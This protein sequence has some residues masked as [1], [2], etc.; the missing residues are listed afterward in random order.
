MIIN[1]LRTTTIL[2]INNIYKKVFLKVGKSGGKSVLLD[3]L[4]RYDKIT[5]TI[6]AKLDAKGRVFLPSDFRKQLAE[7]DPRLVLK[8]DVYQP[9]LVIYPYA[10]W[11]AEVDALRAR[12]NR[13]DPRQAMLFRQFLANV[14]VF[15]LD[16]N[17]RFLISRKMLDACAITDRT[18]RFM[19]VDDRIEVWSVAQSAKLLMSD[20]DYAESLAKIMGET[21]LMDNDHTAIY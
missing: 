14:E 20:S 3:I 15:T 21:P 6:D 8:R 17:G 4:R 7:S 5:G 18:V 12:L 13:W 19:G 16:G 10:V 2:T 11:N 9:C 1:K